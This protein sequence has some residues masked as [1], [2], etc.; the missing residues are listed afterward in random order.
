[1]ETPFPSLCWCPF[2]MIQAPLSF[3]PSVRP[4]HFLFRTE[5]ERRRQKTTKRSG[6]TDGI[7]CAK[8]S[9]HARV[10]HS[11][12]RVGMGEHTS[13]ASAMNAH[14]TIIA[15]DDAAGSVFTESHSSSSSPQPFQS[16]QNIF[17]GLSIFSAHSDVTLTFVDASLTRSALRSRK[18]YN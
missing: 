8:R 1:M 13:S 10:G 17:N 7:S 3:R 16:L 18:L 14:V 6:R 9:A 12:S 15:D 4:L 2:S 5:R 11:V